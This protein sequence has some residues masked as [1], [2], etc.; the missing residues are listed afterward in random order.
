MATG[1]SLYWLEVGMSYVIATSEMMS[2]A[3]TDLAAMG[4][5]VNAAH[6]VAAAPTVAVIPSAADEVSAGIAH[7]F[8]AHARH[9]QALAGQAAAFHQQF[10]QNMTGAAASYSS[11][12][13]GIAAT[14]TPTFPSLVDFFQFLQSDFV[15]ASGNFVNSFGSFPNVRLDQLGRA[16][17][18]VLAFLLFPITY[19]VFAVTVFI[20]EAV[21]YAII[22]AFIP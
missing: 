14:L 6:L 16:G 20:A 10:V 1:P 2:S 19:P 3:A 9:F 7:L 17:S 15:T 12:E 18:D 8:S 5:N 4:A 13:S 11:A 22:N 21:I